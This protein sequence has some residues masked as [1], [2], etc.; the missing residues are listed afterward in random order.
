M[1]CLERDGQLYVAHDVYIWNKKPH[2]FNFL[3]KE[4]FIEKHIKAVAKH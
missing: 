3:F 1:Y 4:I 2:L